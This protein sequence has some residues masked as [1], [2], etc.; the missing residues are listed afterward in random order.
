MKV[1][2][3]LVRI[4]VND[5][6]AALNFYEN[7]LGVKCDLK[8]SYSEVGLELASVGPFLLLGG[9]DAD[10]N[11]FRDTNATLIVDSLAEFKEFL[12]LNGGKVIR[13][14]KIVPTGSNMTV[15]HSDGSII[16]YV[17]HKN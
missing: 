17:Q 16:E 4:Y 7:L 11:T 6:G 12:E 13:G 3:A 2:R 14:P 5:L 1:L 9:A 8:F 15:K 10:L